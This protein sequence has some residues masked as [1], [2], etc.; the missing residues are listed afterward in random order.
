MSK[1]TSLSYSE[2]EKA[3]EAPSIKNA[4]E[5]KKYINKTNIDIIKIL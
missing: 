5:E 3:K 2:R 1:I 4:H